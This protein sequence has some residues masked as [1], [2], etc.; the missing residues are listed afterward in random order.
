MADPQQNVS[1]EE[2]EN[3]YRRGLEEQRR[4]NANVSEQAGEEEG[5]GETTTQKKDDPA[6]RLRNIGTGM[7]VAGGAGQVA[8]KTANV[9]GKGVEAAGEGMQAAGTGIDV[10]GKGVSAVGRGVRK[11]GSAMTRAGVELSSTGIGA[12]AGV[13]L[14]IAGG[15]TAVAGAGTEVAGKGVTAA[16]RGVRVAGRGVQNTGSTIS[17]AG[18]GLN[19]MGGRL[20]G[21]G[22]E[23]KTVANSPLSELGDTSQTN[24]LKRE[25]AKTKKAAQDALRG[26]VI[27]GVEAIG[28]EVASFAL[29]RALSLAWE[30]LIP[31]FGL[32]L[33]WINIHFVAHYIFHSEKFCAF[34]DE[35]SI[36]SGK[37]SK[38]MPGIEYA[39][40]MGMVVLDLLAFVLILVIT[41]VG[42][43]LIRSITG[44][45]SSGGA[46]ASGGF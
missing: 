43:G 15:A 38:L 35:W 26:D 36:T 2:R 12:I 4:Q 30:F 33:I 20:G 29:A 44:G 5:F 42:A 45:G 17:S 24:I 28:T 37:G 13:P 23:L 19:R 41:G 10:A 16:G 22:K 14:A 9:A 32:S 40:I 46:G 3:E 21:A 31:T 25:F 11:A 8:G 6:K 1:Q 34:G 27:G 18:Q 39:E 7:Q